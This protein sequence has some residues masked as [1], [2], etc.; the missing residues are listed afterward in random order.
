LGLALFCLAPCLAIERRATVSIGP[1]AG[2]DPYLKAALKELRVPVSIVAAGDRSD[3]H[4][5]LSLKYQ[6]GDA[7]KLYRKST[8]RDE[9][10]ILEL[11]DA[12][13]KRTLTSCE[14]RLS[15]DEA[16]MRRI[17]RE[18]A[19]SIAARLAAP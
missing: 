1:L 8:G 3:L 6:T 13:T 17:A 12:S 16:G 2:L 15:Q 19:A 4:V 5:S 7:A 11:W 18:F 10:T 9:D 14:F